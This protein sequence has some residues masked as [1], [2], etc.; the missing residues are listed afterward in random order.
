[1]TEEIVGA[2]TPAEAFSILMDNYVDSSSADAIATAEAGKLLG[3]KKFVLTS[4]E[5]RQKAAAAAAKASAGV[6]GGDDG[7]DD[8]EASGAKAAAASAGVQPVDD[9]DDDDEDDGECKIEYLVG[10]PAEAFKVWV[11]VRF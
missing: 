7:E 6:R 3:I 8:D 11:Q 10:L 9:S 5:Q 2:R 1:M 4:L